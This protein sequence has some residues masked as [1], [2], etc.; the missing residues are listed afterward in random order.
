MATGLTHLSVVVSYKLET[1]S[2][3]GV[4]RLK[5]QRSPKVTID[6]DDLIF[7]TRF[8]LYYCS[9]CMDKV[10]IE[11]PGLDAIKFKVPT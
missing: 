5:L 1:N 11:G 9:L 3:L 2:M 10:R 7:L 8:G 6:L 4:S